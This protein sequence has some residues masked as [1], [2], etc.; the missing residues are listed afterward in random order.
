MGVVLGS[1]LWRVG[2]PGELGGDEG[3]EGISLGMVGSF[4]YKRREVLDGGWLGLGFCLIVLSLQFIVF[5]LI[6]P[7]RSCVRTHNILILSSLIFIFLNT[8]FFLWLF[9][10]RMLLIAIQQPIH[11][12]KIRQIHLIITLIKIYLFIYIRWLFMTVISI[13]AIWV[14]I[15]QFRLILLAV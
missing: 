5:L 6:S 3:A 13:V 8:S 1:G 14:L 9:Q 2:L 11:P 15:S 4:L 7:Y 10:V 12:L